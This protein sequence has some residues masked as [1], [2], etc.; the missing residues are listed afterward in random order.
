MEIG[1][2][3]V[4]CEEG[5]GGSRTRLGEPQ[6]VLQICQSLGQPSVDI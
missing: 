2:Q 3:E 1:V 6:A 5:R 4:Y